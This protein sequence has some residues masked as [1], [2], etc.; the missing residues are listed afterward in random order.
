MRLFIL[1]ALF[2]GLCLGQ[3]EINVSDTIKHHSIRKAVLFSVVVPG[4]GQVYNHMHM[5]KGQK[6]AYWKVPLIYAGL[7]TT[8][9]Y[10][11]KNYNLQRALKTEYNNRI[12]SLD[13]DPQWNMYDNQGVLTLY[14]QHRNRQDLFLLGTIFVYALQ[15]ADAGVEAHFVN[16]DV[17]EDL[18]MSFSPQS[19]I[20]DRSIGLSIKLNFR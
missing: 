2:S 20:I 4:A 8:G 12:D 18:S 6:K 13:I 16:F 19:S 14:N 15:I 5:P 3:T 7:G 11:V 10:F 1:F 9:Y 17:S